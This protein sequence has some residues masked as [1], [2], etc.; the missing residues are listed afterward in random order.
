MLKKLKN[1]ITNKTDNS[2]FQFIK[3]FFASG[4]ALFAD[5]SILFILTE[6]FNVYYIVS[7]TISFLAG[8]AITYILSKFYIFTKT[9]IHNKI[10]E[11][12]V[13][14]VIGIIGLILNNIFLYIFT[15][16][17]GIYYMLSKIF[18][19]IVTYLWNYFAR[20]KFIFS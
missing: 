13:F 11:F 4:I 12:T 7:A 10:N 3:Y 6:Y 18:V 2:Y 16:Y 15:E 19:I 20:K 9:K 17:F 1:F 8:I 14:L 5:V